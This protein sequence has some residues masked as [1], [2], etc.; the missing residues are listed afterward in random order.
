M[1]GSAYRKIIVDGVVWCRNT[2]STLIL[3][4]LMQSE[5]DYFPHSKVFLFLF[6]PSNFAKAVTCPSLSHRIKFA[7]LLICWLPAFWHRDT[8]LDNIS[9]F[10]EAYET[11][12]QTFMKQNIKLLLERSACHTLQQYFLSKLTSTTTTFE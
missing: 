10:Y 3:F 11:K 9:Y 2:Q 7:T 4:I 1:P 8:L 12:Y 5:I 6:Y